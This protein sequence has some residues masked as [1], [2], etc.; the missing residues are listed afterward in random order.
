MNKIYVQKEEAL[1]LA[2]YNM[3]PERS[4]TKLHGLLSQMGL[5]I[6]ASTLNTANRM[7]KFPFTGSSIRRLS[8]RY[9]RFMPITSS[10]R[11]GDSSH[12]Q[13]AW[14]SPLGCLT[15]FCS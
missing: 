11:S 8:R 14:A 13:A 5:R 1:F 12:C 6:A 15:G 7:V 3:G 2:Y 4:L 10:K 9:R